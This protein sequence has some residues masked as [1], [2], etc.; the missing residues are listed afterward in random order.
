MNDNQNHTRF[1]QMSNPNMSGLEHLLSY[2]Q[3][4]YTYVYV[5]IY[6]YIYI[7]GIA[8]IS[9]IRKTAGEGWSNATTTSEH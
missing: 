9:F 5:Y 4:N 3:Y 7:D 2:V 1:A 6:I 8:R